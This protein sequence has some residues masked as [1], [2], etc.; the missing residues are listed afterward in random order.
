MKWVGNKILKSI[1][2][3]VLDEV[4]SVITRL[5]VIVI[6]TDITSKWT[7]EN[8]ENY[9]LIFQVIKFKQVVEED[10][11]YFLVLQVWYLK[12]RIQSWSMPDQSD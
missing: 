1:S 11:K 4:L 8:V 5:I 12:L 9:L 7:V 10:K 3:I 6:A 2:T